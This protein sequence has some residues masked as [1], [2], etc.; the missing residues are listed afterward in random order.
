MATL[1]DVARHL[2]M[3][4]GSSMVGRAASVGGVS[5]GAGGS[6]SSLRYGYAVEDSVDGWVK[7]QLDTSGIVSEAQVVTCVCDSPIYNGQRV[8]VDVLPSGQLRARP[9]SENI[10][11]VVEK[12]VAQQIKESG[13]AILA[14]VNGEMEEWKADHQL[15]DADIEHSITTAVSGATETWEA[16]LSD[17]EAGIETNYALKTEVSQG[18]DGLRSEISETYA[19]SEGVSNEINTA[20]EQASGEISSTVEQNVMNSVGDTFATKTELTQTST[21]LTLN[22]N[23]AVSTANT[24]NSNASTA[25]STAQKVES[26]FTFDSTGLEVGRSGNRSSVKMNSNGSFQVLDNGTTVL[27]ISGTNGDYGSYYGQVNIL[28]PSG[29]STMSIGTGSTIVQLES[30]SSAPFHLQYGTYAGFNLGGCRYT[31]VT[32]GSVSNTSGTTTVSMANRVYSTRAC[33]IYYYLSAT[34]SY[35]SVK[36]AISNGDSSTV[37]LVCPQDNGTN[38]IYLLGEQ[39]TVSV[40][41]SGNSVTISRSSANNFRLAIATNGTAYNSSPGVLFRITNVSLCG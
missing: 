3:G 6:T 26:Y 36:F 22:I 24:A 10:V 17:V 2:Y 7:V 23:Q 11:S 25:L 18:I 33:V 9:I 19:T 5:G 14:E 35:Q 12:D 27:N 16:Q 40:N 37:T 34:S 39:I 1:Y 13:D 30:G 15:T 29:N 38:G 32:T 4:K 41:S 8:V 28:T 20:I 31:E 21:S